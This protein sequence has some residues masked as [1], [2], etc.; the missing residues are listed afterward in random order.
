MGTE[1]SEHWAAVVHDATATGKPVHSRVFEVGNMWHREPLDGG[2]CSHGHG[3]DVAADQVLALEQIECDP[4]CSGR[5][6]GKRPL[7]APVW[8]PRTRTPLKG[9]RGD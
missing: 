7:A 1:I 2:G 6:E 5:Q 9:G 8:L 4:C 3:R